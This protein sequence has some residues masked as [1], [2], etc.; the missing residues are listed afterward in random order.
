MQAGMGGGLGN[1]LAFQL[2]DLGGQQPFLVGELAGATCGPLLLAAQFGQLVTGKHGSQFK[3]G[4][5][6]AAG[7]ELGDQVTLL[8]QSFQGL[9]QP[10]G[11]GS[12]LVRNRAQL[13]HLPR[14]RGQ[15]LA[16][17]DLSRQLQGEF[18][19]GRGRHGAFL[20]DSDMP[21]FEGMAE[22]VGLWRITENQ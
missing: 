22:W 8:G 19:G 20:R 18:E 9:R 7:L 13:L 5:G 4:Q 14:Q 21:Q 10:L 11:L 2:L 15:I 16:A 17:G 6:T 1:Q 3:L 12:S